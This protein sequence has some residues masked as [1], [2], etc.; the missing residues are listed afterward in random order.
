M[1]KPDGGHVKWGVLWFIVGVIFTMIVGFNWG[2]WVTGGTAN[3]LAT[4]RSSAAV[5][6]ALTP[7]CVEKA[8][9]PGEAKKLAGVMAVESSWEQMDAF[10]KAGWAIPPGGNE[11]NRDV[12]EACAAQVLKSAGKQAAGK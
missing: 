3:K 10:M 5:A 2:G 9:A 6:K 11:P 8:T 4:D 1:K 12:A 7:L